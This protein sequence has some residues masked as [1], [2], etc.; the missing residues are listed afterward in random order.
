MDKLPPEIHQ[1]IVGFVGRRVGEDSYPVWEHRNLP[2]ARPALAAVSRGFQYAVERLTF[3]SL[4][5]STSP[6]DLDALRR[7]MTPQRRSFLRRLALSLGIDPASSKSSSSRPFATDEERRA[8]N[9]R[10]TSRLRDCFD[11]LSSWN[12]SDSSLTLE[13][14]GPDLPNESTR[15]QTPDY[16]RLRFSLLDVSNDVTDFPPLPMIKELYVNSLTCHLHPH[17]ALALT[18]KMPNASRVEW[19]LSS[20]H[21]TSW[22]LYHHMP[23]IWREG[24]VQ[25]VESAALPSS[26]ERFSFKMPVPGT[27]KFQILPD[28]LGPDPAAL[29]PVSLALRRLTAGCADVFIEGSVHPCLFDPP[30]PASAADPDSAASPPPPPVWERV[31]SLQVNVTMR[32]PDGKWLFKPE[33]GSGSG[34]DDDGG[35]ELEP[36]LPEDLDFERLPPGYGAT[37][38]DLDAAEAYYDEFEETIAPETI[39]AE[40]TN[41]DDE[42]EEPFRSRPDSAR[43]NAL[44]AAFARGCDAEMPVLESAVLQCELDDVDN[45]PWQV[46][47]F[48]ADKPAGDGWDEKY[49]GAAADGKV[50]RFFFHLRDWRPDEETLEVF[51]RVGRE[52][53]TGDAAVCYLPWG[54]RFE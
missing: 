16:T 6:E 47:C 23:R 9:E 38:E 22:G 20:T 52:R 29:D 14:N 36:E 34:N 17:L 2:Y 24:L 8:I 19:D 26:V 50:W 12:L 31:K 1:R 39:D 43:L 54:E 33:S 37:E 25:A 45:W 41:S 49:A 13:V 7:I 28:L 42:D 48:P 10:T 27:S 11:M 40:R 35:D 32:S 53:G 18:T 15:A 4:R 5:L 44:L 51:R 30:A 3:K 21:S 46:V